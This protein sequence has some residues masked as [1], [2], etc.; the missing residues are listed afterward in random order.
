MEEKYMD[1]QSE[2]PFPG[3]KYHLATFVSYLERTGRNLRKPFILFI[4]LACSCCSL[5]SQPG[6]QIPSLNNTGA[7]PTE[8]SQPGITPSGN[9]PAPANLSDVK[10]IAH[11]V[12][13][14]A[15]TGQD[16]KPLLG[17][18][19]ESLGITVLSEGADGKQ[20]V[21]MIKLGKPVIFDVQL[22]SLALGYANGMAVN[23][24][25]FM[26]DLATHGIMD[27]STT[28]PLT[29][30]TLKAAMTSLVGKTNYAPTET[31]PALVIALGQERVTRLGLTATDP[32]L[33][34][35]W[36]DPL[37][38]ALLTYG[39]GFPDIQAVTGMN[40]TKPT[41]NSGIITWVKNGISQNL[42]G[43]WDNFINGLNQ[44]NVP[45]YIICG[46]YYINNSQIITSGPQAVYHKQTDVS[47]P[48][49]YQATVTAT[50][51]LSVPDP[52]QS[53]LLTL[54][55]CKTPPN[56]GRVPNK[57]IRWSLD[58]VAQQHGQ[59]TQTESQTKADGT[60]VAIYETIPET[61]PQ[62]GRIPLAM[63]KVQGQ[64]QV[65]ALDLVDGHPQLEAS[66]RLLGSGVKNTYY[67]EIRF[68]SNLALDVGGSFQLSNTDT[69]ITHAIA[70][71]T[72]PLTNANGNLQGSG[73][74]QVSSTATW[75]CGSGGTVNGKG[76]FTGKI[77]VIAT[78]G[79]GSNNDQLTFTL[80]PDITMLT[81]PVMNTQC[82]SGN[83]DFE[84]YGALVILLAANFTLNST[85]STYAYTPPD[86]TGAINFSLHV[87]SH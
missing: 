34:D 41:A 25:S 5:S 70:N 7:A 13:D 31:L 20:G 37:Q 24:D 51:F 53:D 83:L 47:S 69:T 71:Q 43:F 86:A 74:L 84:A 66:G 29:S 42:P 17:G 8:S 10:A 50:L 85:T 32:V 58:S 9:A 59:F 48:P 87:A 19:F 68:Y 67:L 2:Y 16:L 30:A 21:A 4:I 76:T 63:Q 14:Q 33:G 61:A 28:G 36:L 82:V 79:S 27:A 18:I 23:L 64:L 78:P 1:R 22:D 57:T 55:G 39:F 73:S 62:V 44:L 11:Q 12:Y 46:L 60:A 15:Q 35:G 40:S 6:G 75:S 81:P 72:I 56:P 80:I 49:P 38:Y 65:E 26:A 54:A 52:R 77:Q 3:N 45:D